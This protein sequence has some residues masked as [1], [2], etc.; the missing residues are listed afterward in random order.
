MRNVVGRNTIKSRVLE[1]LNEHGLL[2]VAG[3]VELLKPEYPRCTE[4]ALYLNHVK[5]LHSDKLVKRLTGAFAI[6]TGGQAELKRLEVE[7]SKEGLVRANLF[8]P[9][10]VYDGA[11]LRKTCMR[12][13]AYDAYRVKSIINGKIHNVQS[14]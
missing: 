3:L 10:G 1:L 7:L 9:S 5:E 6:T 13:G 2:T 11:E 12:P 4:Q 8:V 14:I